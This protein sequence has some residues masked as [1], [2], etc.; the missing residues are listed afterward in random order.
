MSRQ[1]ANANFALT[2]FLDGANATYIDEM[3][4][5]YEADPSS[6]DPE[7]QSFFKS[8]N[9]APADVEKNARGPSWEKPSP[10]ARRLPLRPPAT[11]TSCR[12]RGTRFAL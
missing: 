2:S 9:D 5:R 7:W 10:S 4:A 12:R 11:R 8:L 1:D 3:Y 6:V